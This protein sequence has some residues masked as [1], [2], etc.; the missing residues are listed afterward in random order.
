M[1][2]SESLV[3]FFLMFGD[4]GASTWVAD[5]VE[6]VARAVVVREVVV[7][8]ADVRHTDEDAAAPDD[9]AVFCVSS[10]NCM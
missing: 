4:C 2:N 5:A 3:F 6:R 10:P 7:R 1:F 9:E 8:E